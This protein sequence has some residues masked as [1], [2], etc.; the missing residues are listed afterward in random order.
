VTGATLVL[1][2]SGGCGASLIAGGLALRWAADGSRPWLVEL[3]LERGDLAGAW[4]LPAERTVGDLAPVAA[5]LDARHVRAAA[6]PHPS[7]V[8][9]LPGPGTPGAAAGW[10]RESVGRLLEVVAAEGR[11]VAD[12]G[13]G[14][15]RVAA[16]AAER[17]GEVIVVC[18]PT[19]ASARRARRLLDAVEA[20]GRSRRAVVVA[21]GPVRGDLGA[22]ALGRALE[23]GVVAEI[24]WAE[25]EAREIAAGR[26]PGGRRGRLRGAIER[27][28][29]ALA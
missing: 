12:A 8:V 22:R 10:D 25:A 14:L 18:A 1:G 26:W 24:P 3:D 2:A 9:V 21:H 19:L 6:F 7:G 20:A 4:D 29:E 23:A 17:A 15:S 11:V 27:L 5:E 13:A 16:A 28:A